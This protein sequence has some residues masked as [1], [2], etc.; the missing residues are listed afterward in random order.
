MNG[1]S[2]E[3][4]ERLASGGCGSV[5]SIKEGA[6]KM[7]HIVKQGKKDARRGETNPARIP[8]KSVPVLCAAGSI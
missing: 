6:E 3:K 4:A 8:Q 2:V 1:L 5:K 7:F